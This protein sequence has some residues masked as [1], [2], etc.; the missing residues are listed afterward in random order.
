MLNDGRNN[1]PQWYHQFHSNCVTFLFLRYDNFEAIT[2]V[3]LDNADVDSAAT[4]FYCL[5]I[6]HADC[7]GSG[8]LPSCCDGIA[9]ECGVEPT[10]DPEVT[11]APGMKIYALQFFTCFEL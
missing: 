3:T 6:Q 11:E 9:C 5:D 8:L 2:G 4:Y 1:N 10:R 7:I